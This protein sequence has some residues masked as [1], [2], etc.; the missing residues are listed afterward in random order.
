MEEKLYGLKG[1]VFQDP[2]SSISFVRSDDFLTRTGS[3]EGPRDTAYDLRDTG[4]ISLRFLRAEIAY[5]LLFGGF[6]F[7]GF[8]SLRGDGEDDD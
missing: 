1:L 6:W 7:V 4:L 5:S 3:Y 8:W 2:S